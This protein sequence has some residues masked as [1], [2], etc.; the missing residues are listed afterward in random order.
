MTEQI[1][2]AIIAGSVASFVVSMLTKTEIWRGTALGLMA[3]LAISIGGFLNF[4]LKWL[5][6]AAILV[7]AVVVLS[8]I[9]RI[10]P[11]KSA[12]ISFGSVISAVIVLQIFYPNTVL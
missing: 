10:T 11:K 12:A 8:Q 1:I 7:V 2:A 3:I 9:L 4:E 6:Q 5:F